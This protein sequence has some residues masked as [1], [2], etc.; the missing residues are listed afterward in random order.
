M[1]ACVMP[2]DLVRG[3]DYSTDTF[4]SSGAFNSIMPDNDFVAINSMTEQ[5]IQDFLISYNS[6]AEQTIPSKPELTAIFARLKWQGK[7]SMRK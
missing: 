2:L 7:D 4:I 1:L 3:A 5:Q 6:T